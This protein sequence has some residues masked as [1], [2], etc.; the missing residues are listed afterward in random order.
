MGAMDRQTR[1]IF[2]CLLCATVLFA[3]E[4]F[5]GM[6]VPKPTIV[7]CLLTVCGMLYLT[8]RWTPPGAKDLHV[9]LAA[10]DSADP[11]EYAQLLAEETTF[12]LNAGPEVSGRAAVLKALADD[13]F[14]LGKSFKHSITRSW[15]VGESYVAELSL[16]IV[17]KDGSTRTVPAA[18]FIDL[19][20]GK[21]GATKIFVTV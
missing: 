10:L 3:A 12:R 20:G 15:E 17:C 13:Y 21:I 7:A 5:T 9:V 4:D 11:K 2:A 8:S 6:P 14:K 1:N 19:S 18:M 16:T